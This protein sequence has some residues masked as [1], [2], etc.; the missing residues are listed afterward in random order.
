MTLV[1]IVVICALA[2]SLVTPYFDETE[3]SSAAL[4]E[5]SEDAKRL[6]EDDTLVTLPSGKQAVMPAIPEAKGE[7]MSKTNPFVMVEVVPE[8]A[9]QEL[10]Y[11][12]KGSEGIDFD[13]MLDYMYGVEAGGN[14]G[15]YGDLL[16][17]LRSFFS[18]IYVEGSQASVFFG[19]KPAYEFIPDAY[20]IKALSRHSEEFR[21]QYHALIGKWP[22][23]KLLGT[24]TKDQRLIGWK[25]QAR[26]PAQKKTGY[27]Q[28]VELG[29][30]YFK[31]D[32]TRFIQLNEGDNNTTY[33]RP[34]DFDYIFVETAVQ[35]ADAVAFA[36]DLPVGS[37]VWVEELEVI[38][39]TFRRAQVI[40]NDLFIKEIFC[41]ADKI[42]GKKNSIEGF[43]EGDLTGPERDRYN[44]Y[45]ADG[46][47]DEEALTII[48]GDLRQ[49]I[50][51]A[52]AAQGSTQWLSAPANVQKYLRVTGLVE[53][54]ETVYANLNV[55]VITVT[56]EMLNYSVSEAGDDSMDYIERADLMYFKHKL[57]NNGI[58]PYYEAYT[59]NMGLERIRFS[60]ND[61][62]RPNFSESTNR[63]NENTM[64][65]FY[66]TY[67]TQ[68]GNTL[69]DPISNDLSWETTYKV[70]ERLG[71]QKTFPLIMHS[72]QILDSLGG[73]NGG[74]SI[75][76]GGDVRY[77][78]FVEDG[79]NG[80]GDIVHVNHRTGIKGYS[81][82]L[83]KM[84]YMAT[85]MDQKRFYDDVLP[86]IKG[87]TVGETWNGTTS[88]KRTG[89]FD[90]HV[91]CGDG[92]ADYNVPHESNTSNIYW[93][94]KIFWPNVSMKS[95]NDPRTGQP[96]T[97][98]KEFLINEFGFFRHSLD[99]G[100]GAS[101]RMGN[102]I[103]YHNG[104]NIANLFRTYAKHIRDIVNSRF[105]T[106]VQVNKDELS[107][108]NIEPSAEKVNA[109]G[110]V[111]S[112]TKAK[113][114][115]YLNDA[116]AS[117]ISITT[118]TTAE[119][120]GMQEDLLAEYD[121]IYLGCAL[122][123]LNTVAGSG[124]GRTADYNDNNLDGYAYL[125]VGDSIRRGES[126][127]S[128]LSGN[129][130]NEEKAK[131]LIEYV[132]ESSPVIIADEFYDGQAVN[133]DRVDSAS[134]MYDF[135]EEAIEGGNSNVF[136]ESL[137]ELDAAAENRLVSSVNECRQISKNV[138][139]ILPNVYANTFGADEQAA[140]GDNYLSGTNLS[141]GF[142]VKD[143]KEY[144]AALY[145]VEES[146][147]TYG[148]QA[149]DEGRI[150]DDTGLSHNLA[151]HVGASVSWK[152]VVWQN[153]KRGNRMTYTGTSSIRISD[154]EKKTKYVLQITDDVASDS[155]IV[156]GE[157]V[158]YQSYGADA[159][160]AGARIRRYLDATTD[161]D[162]VITTIT[163]GELEA[164][165]DE[166]TRT[167][168]EW[169]ADVAKDVGEE[170]A[171][172]LEYRDSINEPFDP[173]DSDTDRFANIDF[174]LMGC[175]NRF[176]GPM[177]GAVPTSWRDSGIYSNL[178]YFLSEKKPIIF[179]NDTTSMVDAISS[180]SDPAARQGYYI[181]RW[182]RSL[183]G[184]DRY[185]YRDSETG[186]P[187]AYLTDRSDPDNPVE[188]RYGDYDEAYMLNNPNN[189]YTGGLEGY[190]YYG[191]HEIMSGD[192]QLAPFVGMSK[193]GDRQTESVEAMY[194]STV[195]RYPYNIL[196]D[197]SVEDSI[198]RRSYQ[199][200]V[201][202]AHAQSYQLNPADPKV[203]VYAT[204][205]GDEVDGRDAGDKIFTRSPHDAM[206]N[207][208]L[209]QREN[210]IYSGIG[211]TANVTDMEAQLF[212]NT[213]VM[214][215]NM[216]PAAERPE[217]TVSG[218]FRTAACDDS[219]FIDLDSVENN[220][221]GGFANNDMLMVY[222]KVEDVTNHGLVTT[223]VEL[224]DE[225]E[226]A[227]D[228][229]ELEVYSLTESNGGGELTG[230]MDGEK[231]VR[232][233]VM[234]KTSGAYELKSNVW[235]AFAY[236]K[237]WFE[238]DDRHRMT[239][240]AKNSPES[241]KKTREKD[242]LVVERYLFNLD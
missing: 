230:E 130:I 237:R 213:L 215:A 7:K 208:Y 128:R 59:E 202:K 11:Q 34:T 135:M 125:H 163:A 16:G 146:Q 66:R 71:V 104:Q 100:S 181:T 91:L 189:Q 194:D 228:N 145:L 184:L 238:N 173:D 156:L 240:K 162:F 217:I 9:M 116:D 232:A 222:F 206:N 10:T 64:P 76:G 211:N 155:T 157:N 191:L 201:G 132:E 63:M 24:Q 182:F 141:V 234:D 4:T 152:L 101:G 48:F 223:K 27:L 52:F 183:M 207:Y 242:V 120:I 109:S 2:F 21:Q 61:G 169:N 77:H 93:H 123:S 221:R 36:A 136:R 214:A 108:L 233:T 35:P 111:G 37:K 32:G 200:D 133:G 195:M 39:Y 74:L 94:D 83:V 79:V 124:G 193:S 12:V 118:M 89:Y 205:D 137:I 180:N 67:T 105:S 96:Y 138:E 8:L 209:Y 41:V 241:G 30:G 235:Y 170:T 177:G 218:S 192:G 33:E 186:D 51:D 115:T 40:N 28:K 166:E 185:G 80:A 144:S 158:P 154:D 147:G 204:L 84:Y 57:N 236:P 18:K 142:D 95:Y 129:D 50:D 176:K 17:T 43:N 149:V 103:T 5:Q 62:T 203:R 140:G 13:Y 46:L 1:G 65:D 164:L 82:H 224:T 75:Q 78:S 167:E 38:Q 134:Y 86:L 199:V 60:E 174:I 114:S 119:L 92:C 106:R 20:E 6:Y 227:M 53:D 121:L 179:T 122:D 42:P 68:S 26:D 81:N 190:S 178:V 90:R 127:S 97:D 73:N 69:S 49:E 110:E 70:I 212:V 229:A 197:E 22:S 117:K 168:D 72:E 126:G 19:D 226:A 44:E 3:K 88:S 47:S 165:Y 198:T 153:D 150:S 25:T 107:V 54:W 98:Y 85:T 239:I 219:V 210:V 151:G 56:P 45:R 14:G 131:A 159:V 216:T 87:T 29:D 31:H 113:L 187:A 196:D 23:T 102:V 175:A 148:D 220:D 58:I 160:E 139:V 15:K 143:D 171:L 225:E 55:K 188:K 161:Y 172:T 231:S 112:L 99:G